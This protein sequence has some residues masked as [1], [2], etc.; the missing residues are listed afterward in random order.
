MSV[1]IVEDD[2]RIAD[3]VR[4]GLAEVGAATRW[5]DDGLDGLAAALRPDVELV[6]LDLGLPTLD[7]HELLRRLQARRP[8]LPVLILSARDS[9]DD[10]LRG[11]EA[12]AVDYLAK[13]FAVAELVARVQARRRTV[14]PDGPPSGSGRFELDRRSRVARYGEV[15]VELSDR[16]YEV[17]AV[18]L[19]HAPS[20]V[21]FAT[22]RDRVWPEAGASDNALAAV[23]RRLRRKF[24]DGVIETLPG[25]GYRLVG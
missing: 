22:V 9:L 13:P 5:V 1:L 10:R 25:R 2:P 24:P 7:G 21:A 23:V 14:G 12:G 20:P 17:I 11:L 8:D 4:R 6:V 3:L 15:E 16:E 18:L 19:D